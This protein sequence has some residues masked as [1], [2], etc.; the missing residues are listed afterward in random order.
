MCDDED[1]RVVEGLNVSLEP[2]DGRQVQ[3]VRTLV[4]E[5]NIDLLKEGTSQRAARPP[6]TRKGCK[7]LINL[8][9]GE[10]QSKQYRSRTSFSV[11]GV[12][13]DSTVAIRDG[14]TQKRSQI[15]VS[16]SDSISESLS[17]A[18]VEAGC[19]SDASM[20]DCCRLSPT[21]SDMY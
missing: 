9:R 17:K 4:Q 11:P 1:R 19:I 16:R 6:A 2:N 12:Y 10:A 15:T 3:K 5:E 21:V 20:V 8:L 14:S 18:A 7:W 13:L